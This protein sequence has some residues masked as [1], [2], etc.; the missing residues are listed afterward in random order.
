MPKQPGRPV[1]GS[2]SG[3]PIMLLL[4]VLGQRWT[5]RIL[6][7]L[8]A[9]SLTFRQLQGRCGDVSPTLLNQRLKTLRSLQI[10]ERDS[11]GYA[12]TACGREL[13]NHLLDLDAFAK[14]WAG[15][16]QSSA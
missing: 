15:S 4:D 3:R 8:R 13:G 9:G 12:L 16:L 1:R 11:D 5:L 7:E 6:W 2:S 10:I 14:K